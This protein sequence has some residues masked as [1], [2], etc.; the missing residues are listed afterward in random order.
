M[1]Y[2]LLKYV[3]EA[4]AAIIVGTGAGI[5]FFV[6]MA[7][8]SRD[9]SFIARTASRVAF[10][11]LI[12]TAAIFT[13]PLFGVLLLRAAG[14][15]MKESWVIASLVLYAAAGLL[16]LPVVWMQERMTE[17]AEAA[18]TSREPLPQTYH[19]LFRLWYTFG[20][21]GFGAVMVILW[22]MIAK[23]SL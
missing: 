4:G 18:A 13:Q 1:P 15:S 6:L 10:A 16:W 23:P 20:L 14:I 12:L 17:L 21:F 11:N 8:L 3:H 22:L 9:V 2:T 5:A 19:R 7:H